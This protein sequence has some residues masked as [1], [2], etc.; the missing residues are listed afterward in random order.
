MGVS[1]P[2]AVNVEDDGLAHILQIFGAAF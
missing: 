2:E 1:W